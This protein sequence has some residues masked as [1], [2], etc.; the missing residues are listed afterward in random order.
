MDFVNCRK[1]EHDLLLTLINKIDLLQDNFDQLKITQN[2][3]IEQ[4]NNIP[5]YNPLLDLIVDKIES[6]MN[7]NYEG[8]KLYRLITGWMYYPKEKKISSYDYIVKHHIFYPENI[9]ILENNGFKV[10]KNN[11]DEKHHICW[12]KRTNE[13]I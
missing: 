3:L 13:S 2:K 5:I 11:D 10:F 12:G 8:L 4:L 6:H 9:K 7:P 1:P